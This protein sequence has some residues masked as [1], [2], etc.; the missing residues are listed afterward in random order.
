MI[1][2]TTFTRLLRAITIMI[3]LLGRETGRKMVN[4]REESILIG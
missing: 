1:I 4:Y 2:F 3:A